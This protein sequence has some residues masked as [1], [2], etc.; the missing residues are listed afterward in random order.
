MKLHGE[1]LLSIATK[2]YWLFCS[3]ICVGS[4]LLDNIG[5]ILTS[6]NLLQHVPPLGA[7]LGPTGG[8][9]VVVTQVG[10][11]HSILVHDGIVGPNLGN[12]STICCVTNCKVV[13]SLDSISSGSRVAHILDEGLGSGN[14]VC[15]AIVKDTES[16]DILGFRLV[17]GINLDEYCQRYKSDIFMDFPKLIE[18]VNE[19]YMEISSKRIFI[20][21]KY[22]Y[23]M[24]HLLE[25]LI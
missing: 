4:I 8:Y 7:S 24:N 17:E 13:G 3:G 11:Q 23:V 22:F 5:Y 12:V 9:L 19:G 14:L 25:Q 16:P 1:G 20:N 21:Q 15:I 18:F 2:T 10:H 6:A